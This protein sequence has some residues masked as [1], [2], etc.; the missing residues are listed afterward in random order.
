MTEL[1]HFLTNFNVSMSILVGDIDKPP[2][3]TPPWTVLKTKTRDPI[4]LFGSEL[5]Y[6]ENVENFV[7]AQ[8]VRPQ[9]SPLPSRPPPPSRPAPP[10]PNVQPKDVSHNI[11]PDLVQNTT[12]ADKNPTIAQES[13]FDLLNLN[14][15]QENKTSTF[16]E[17][18]VRPPQKIVSFDLLGFEKSDGNNEDTM[19]NIN[20]SSNSNPID[21]LGNATTSSS[22]SGY[23]ENLNLDLNSMNIN[24]KKSESKSFDPFE[25]L[26][27]PSKSQPPS[28]NSPENSQAS[29]PANNQDPFADLGSFSI[30]NLNPAK[31]P[32]NS[33]SQN[34]LNA[35]AH[36][37]QSKIN[38]TPSPSTSTHT[39]PTH[40]S[41]SAQENFAQQAGQKPDYNRLNFSEPKDPSKSASSN[42]PTGGFGDIFA[43]ILGEQGYKFGNKIQ[44]PRTIN[45]MRKEDIVKDMDPDRL[46]IMEW[47]SRVKKNL[48]I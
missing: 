18:P 32:A 33:L 9:K 34:F 46:K 48:N 14:Q 45:D 27:Q 23:L 37:S 2:S 39:T 29:D 7:T 4:I 15:N 17:P 42:K 16:H 11:K 6:Q 26:L 20:N 19:E 25:S 10:S 36:Q 44:Q 22:S 21:L 30:E 31:I 12:Y 5:E 43:D 41:R 3:V 38:Q 1:D 13:T 47:V 35:Q 8:V 28:H 40:Q 24:T